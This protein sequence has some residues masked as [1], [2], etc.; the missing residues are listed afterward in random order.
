MT[1]N[2]LSEINKLKL[3]LLKYVD[4]FYVTQTT[5]KTFVEEITKQL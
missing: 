3:E 1:R 5:K 4:T 2:I